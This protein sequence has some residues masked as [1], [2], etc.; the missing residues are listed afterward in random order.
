MKAILF[1]NGVELKRANYPRKDIG[2]IP[3]LLPGLE[4]KLIVE[5]NRPQIDTRTHKYVKSEN[6]TNASHPDYPHL[7][8]YQIFYNVVPKSNVELQQ[9]VKELEKEANEQILAEQTR[10]K[11]IILGLGILIRKSNGINITAKEQTIL[12]KI[13]AKA[14]NVWQNDTTLQAKLDEINNST[15]PDPDTGWNTNE[16]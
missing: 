9:V 2:P 15:V 6:N 4:W 7:K 16:E 13:L 3:D 8:Q 5:A 11:Y 10:M 14:I 1:E 12:D